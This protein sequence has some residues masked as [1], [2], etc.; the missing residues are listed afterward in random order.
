MIR[1]Y[2]FFVDFPLSIR[3]EYIV[4]VAL[5]IELMFPLGVKHI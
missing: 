4:S 2:V 3:L 1:K 5:S